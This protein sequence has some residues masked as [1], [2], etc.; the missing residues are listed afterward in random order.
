MAKPSSSM[1]I[2][3]LVLL[4]AAW[5]VRAQ[6]TVVV[7]TTA[8]TL[9]QPNLPTAPGDQFQWST[10]PSNA[11]LDIIFYKNGYPTGVTQDP[12]L[13]LQSS[14]NGTFKYVSSP[15]S[16]QTVN[17]NVF[18]GSTSTQLTFKYWQVLNGTPCDGRII[19]I[20]PV[21]K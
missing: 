19:I 5:N 18:N 1:R 8:C 13:N 14:P 20:K 15:T 11:K 4:L 9:S 6:T 12:L 21:K 10:N 2:L 16:A 7:G 17:P 3:P